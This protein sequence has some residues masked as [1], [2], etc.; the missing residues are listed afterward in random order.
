MRCDEEER[1]KCERRFPLTSSGNGSAPSSS[2]I[3]AGKAREELPIG[4]AG[5][6]KHRDMHARVA[7]EERCA[8]EEGGEKSE[9][10]VRHAGVS[11]CAER[12]DAYTSTSKTSVSALSSRSAR[13]L[14][15]P[16]ACTSREKHR[17]Q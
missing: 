12:C 3:P 11:A 15:P 4:P 8:R 13:A 9:E 2:A 10:G 7:S 14:V 5:A 17:R 6:R 1:K 16:E